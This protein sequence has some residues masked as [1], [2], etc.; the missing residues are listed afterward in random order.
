MAQFKR[1]IPTQSHPFVDGNGRTARA[2]ATLI[3]SLKEFDIKKFFSLDDYYDSDRI[4]YY[5]ALNS[6][7]QKTLDLTGWIEYFT[8]GVLLSITKV[9]EKVSQLSLEKHKK[10]TKGQVALTEKQ[11]K[12]IGHI[13][14]NGR[15][16]SGEIQK[17]FKI[18]RPA[19][20]KEIRKLIELNLIEPK[21]SGKAIYYLIK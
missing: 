5:H 15:I 3:L 17:T 4:A 9:K 2:L 16:T 13:I 19:A 12:V 18:S 7:D 10:E 6:V 14:S 1:L 8:D 21:G 20:Y 11:T